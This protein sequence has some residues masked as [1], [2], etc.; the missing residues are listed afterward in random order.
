MIHIFPLY[1]WI[2]PT[3]EGE[4]VDAGWMDGWKSEWKIHAVATLNMQRY[5]HVPTTWSL[6]SL[7]DGV[8][9]MTYGDKCSPHRPVARQLRNRRAHG[10]SCCLGRL[11]K[12]NAVKVV[13]IYERAVMFYYHSKSRYSKTKTIDATY[14]PIFDT[15]RDSFPMFLLSSKIPQ[16]SNALSPL[17]GL[18]YFE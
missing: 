7:F 13:G 14:S 12:H 1:F 15:P 6:C 11:W 16:F 4:C 18:F 9:F 17:N 8:S 2:E 5:M 10:Q 3:T